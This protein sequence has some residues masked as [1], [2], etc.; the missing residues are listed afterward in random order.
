[1]YLCSTHGFV[2]W[3]IRW[4]ERHP[5]NREEGMATNHGITLNTQPWGNT[6]MQTYNQTHT[7]TGNDQQVSTTHVD[8]QCCALGNKHIL[9]C[10]VMWSPLLEFNQNSII[11]TWLTLT[12]KLITGDCF[13]H[14]EAE[15]SLYADWYSFA[16]TQIMFSHVVCKSAVQFTL[17]SGK[18]SLKNVG[19]HDS[20]V[21]KV[22]AV[23]KCVIMTALKNRCSLSDKRH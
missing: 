2:P 17:A 9:W 13:S 10:A 23:H 22:L 3:L 1:M 4:S 11:L 5:L 8:I 6:H 12:Q 19:S 7:G 14:I 15:K 16:L 21:K 18:V 20:S